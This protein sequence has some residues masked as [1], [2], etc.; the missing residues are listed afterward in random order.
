[1]ATMGRVKLETE[2]VF[3]GV[4]VEVVY[5]DRRT[6]RVRLALAIMRV[7]LWLLGMTWREAFDSG[8]PN[9]AE[10]LR[11]M[12][13][14]LAGAKR[15]RRRDA[16]VARRRA[17]EME[18]GRDYYERILRRVVDELGALRLLG[19]VGMHNVVDELKFQLNRL[20]QIDILRSEA[21]FFWLQLIDANERAARLEGERDG[22]RETCVVLEGE[23]ARLRERLEGDGPRDAGPT[24]EVDGMDGVDGV[25]PH[26]RTRTDTDEG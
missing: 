21:T 16:V 10:R 8:Q 1:M 23:I 4:T 19:K 13:R 17:I 18:R 2:D 25:D 24:E 22:A 3:R 9:S 12:A 5:R 6:A 15:R 26:G 14:V 11:V 20:K 7:G